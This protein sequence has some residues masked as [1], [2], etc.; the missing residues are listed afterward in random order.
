MKLLN[1]MLIGYG[2]LLLLASFGTTLLALA[3]VVAGSVPAWETLAAA[4]L[5]LIAL[6][7][8][9]WLVRSL[10]RD[11]SGP[12][13][14]LTRAARAI[15]AGHFDVRVPALRI[16][17][18]R[19]LAGSF[20]EMAAALEIYNSTSIDRLLAEQ[21]RSEAV[22]TS[23]DDGL[24]IVDSNAC[25]ERMNPVAARQLGV[26]AAAAE[27]RT[28]DAIIGRA[29]L[30]A[31][32]L[33]RVNRQY[34]PLDPDIDLQIG[35]PPLV[36]TLSC[37]L[38]PFH[39]LTRPGLVLVLRDVTADRELERLR[40][41]FVLHASHE[42]RTPV[43]GLRMALQ[44]LAERCRFAPGSREAD[45]IETVCSE[46]ER[47]SLLVNDLLDLSRL[48]SAQAPLKRASCML[49]ELVGDAAARFGPLAAEAQLHLETEIAAK[50]PSVQLDAAQFSR[51]LD[52]LVGNAIRHTPPGGTVRIAVHA[53]DEAIALEVVDS[54]EGMPARQLRRIFDPF[55]QLGANSGGAGLG[56]TL[57]R[58]IVE[59]H[60]GRITV[61][62]R[63]G[64]GTAFRVSLPWA[65]AGADE[66]E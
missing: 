52:N 49:D 34:S 48:N 56:L 31:E 58:E 25:I 53:A 45:L 66:S 33:E 3:T 47:L 57:C 2:S 64:E 36:R 44:L 35:V 7:G 43:S 51:V 17:E 38:L 60:G 37:T 23:I 11:I 21:R 30:D 63:V 46:T 10:A 4:M 19:T 61:Q 20:N 42:L 1:R 32:V 5:S 40:N 28:P 8:G 26:S 39:D 14:Q 41:D 65:I 55:V 6:G 62:S 29:V 9:I 13:E 12:F 16:P 18:A 15:A 24:I 22:L 50:L 59:Q 54:G 27:G